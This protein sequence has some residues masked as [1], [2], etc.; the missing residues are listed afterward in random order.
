VLTPSD[1]FYI[2]HAGKDKQ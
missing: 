2:K 1:L